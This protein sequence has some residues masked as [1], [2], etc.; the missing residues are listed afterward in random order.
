MFSRRK[1]QELNNF[2]ANAKNIF[3]E[4]WSG[5]GSSVEVPQGYVNQ[6]NKVR[7]VQ[8]IT[9]QLQS[10]NRLS[11]EV[12]ARKVSMMGVHVRTDRRQQLEEISARCYEALVEIF[13]EYLLQKENLMKEVTNKLGYYHE[14]T[15]DLYKEYKYSITQWKLAQIEQ[16]FAHFLQDILDSS[17]EAGVLESAD[18]ALANQFR[19]YMSEIINLLEMQKQEAANFQI[20]TLEVTSYL[21][22]FKNAFYT[23]FYRNGNYTNTLFN[24]YEFNPEATIAIIVGCYMKLINSANTG[25]KCTAT[26]GQ[27]AV[28]NGKTIRQLQQNRRT[29]LG[30]F[31]ESEFANLVAMSAYQI[32]SNISTLQN[33]PVADSQQFEDVHE[34]FWGSIQQMQASYD[35]LGQG[36][37]L[38]EYSRVWKRLGAFNEVFS[39]DRP[40]N[41]NGYFASMNQQLRQTRFSNNIVQVIPETRTNR[42]LDISNSNESEYESAQDNGNSNND[43]ITNI[44]NTNGRNNMINNNLNNNQQP[45]YYNNHWQGGNQPYTYYNHHGHQYQGVN[46]R[47]ITNNMRKH[48]RAYYKN[49]SEVKTSI[50]VLSKIVAT[51]H[52]NRFKSLFDKKQTHIILNKRNGNKRKRKISLIK[53]TF[54]LKIKRFKVP[55]MITRSKTIKSSKRVSKSSSKQPKTKRMSKV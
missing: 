2:L 18:T 41:V 3:V 51:T 11:S 43:F 5:R 49:I 33:A 35:Q 36:L 16:A 10:A 37:D 23:H 15:T 40:N 52:K 48:I 21:A 27:Y 25:I 31:M 34:S 39:V 7:K 55:K 1:L 38:P 42:Q 53:R 28:Y 47:R 45:H 19:T 17:V 13:N 50:K 44:M 22:Y 8:E 20:N 12:H 30:S 32:G 54:K 6:A 14:G 9:Q 29:D 46:S 26:R 4:A 24:C